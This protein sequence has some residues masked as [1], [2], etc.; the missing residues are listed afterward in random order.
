MS[1][2][3]SLLAWQRIE[4]LFVFL[5]MLV[6]YYW[7]GAPWWIFLL[8]FLVPDLSMLG[9]LAGPRLGAFAYNLAHAYIGPALLLGAVVLLTD[10][11]WAPSALW[12]FA[13]LAV[14]WASHIAFDRL[15]GYGLKSPEGF[16]VTHLGPIGRKDSET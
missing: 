9:Y 12:D 7:S 8:L 14:I 11:L 2:K 6:L 1:S 16:G 13:P 4:A 5:A 10:L 3:K 15:L